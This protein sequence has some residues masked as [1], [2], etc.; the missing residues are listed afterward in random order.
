[1][2]PRCRHTFAQIRPAPVE[3]AH[4]VRICAD[5][6]RA[7]AD[8]AQI[9]P[10]LGHVRPT[11]RRR[12]AL[13][14]HPGRIRSVSDK[15][16]MEPA[17]LDKLRA[18]FGRC[19]AEYEQTRP[20]LGRDPSNDGR[21]RLK[22]GPNLEQID[23]ISSSVGELGPRIVYQ[24]RLQSQRHCHRG[25]AEQAAYR[26]IVRAAPSLCC[27]ICGPGEPI[28]RQ[29]EAVEGLVFVRRLARA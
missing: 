11:S 29:G 20:V 5:V 28:L 6:G 22:L 14:A 16:G 3:I 4:F 1:M 10:M 19:W 7:L 26:G 9:W 23:A 21:T 24:F 13:W 25:V 15:V 12:R 2:L 27:R 18:D 8:S 17:K